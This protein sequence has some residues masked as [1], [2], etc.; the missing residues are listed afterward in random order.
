MIILGYQRLFNLLRP[1][2]QFR[3][4]CWHIP[5]PARSKPCLE[6]RPSQPVCAESHKKLT[7]NP[8]FSNP[9]LLQGAAFERQS[10][11]QEKRTK[12]WQFQKS[13]GSSQSH[14]VDSWTSLSLSGLGLKLSRWCL[15]FRLKCL[16]V[17]FCVTS[18][19]FYSVLP[20]ELVIRITN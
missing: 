20:A 15:V 17:L 16:L 7:T 14:P 1:Y 12:S 6:N 2:L 3:D 8:M 5:I 10:L 9:N 18:G 11:C 19:E 4:C 13:T